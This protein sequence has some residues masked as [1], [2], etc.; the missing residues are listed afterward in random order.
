MGKGHAVH[1]TSVTLALPL[2]AAV[3]RGNPLQHSRRAERRMEPRVFC[4]PRHPVPRR[5]A[6][7]QWP[8]GTRWCR[9]Y[10]WPSIYRPLPLASVV[11]MFCSYGR[12]GARGLQASRVLLDSSFLNGAPCCVRTGTPSR[13]TGG[14]RPIH[15]AAREPESTRI[16]HWCLV[17]VRARRAARGRRP[18][19]SRALGR[20]VAWVDRPSAERTAGKR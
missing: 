18:G 19:T 20:A 11:L 17:R 9:T 10:G 3:R 12:P 6:R 5:L 16:G 14:R 7:L 8:P 13:S 15:G 1:G 2:P 4:R